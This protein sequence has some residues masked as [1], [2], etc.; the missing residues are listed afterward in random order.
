[1]SPDVQIESALML[2]PGEIFVVSEDSLTK[3]RLSMTDL[4]WADTEQ[5]PRRLKTPHNKYLEHEYLMQIPVDKKDYKKNDDYYVDAIRNYAPQIGI[6]DP[7]QLSAIKR[8]KS[9]P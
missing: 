2:K 8:W 6:L 7:D 4:S 5:R 1:M 9:L 3:L